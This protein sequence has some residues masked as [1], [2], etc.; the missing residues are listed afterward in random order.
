[1]ARLPD[2]FSLQALPIEAALSEGRTE[3]AKTAIC[4]LLNAGKAD[5]IVQRLA[6]SLIKP[7][8]RKRGRRA[9]HTRHWFEIGEGF[10]SMRSVGETYEDTL[11]A[12][13]KKFGYSETHIRKAVTEYND[14]KAAADEANRD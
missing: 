11:V 14:A 6:A 8:K 12:L 7:P 13:A 5:A 3:D 4:A 1:M 9:A 10:H 2:G